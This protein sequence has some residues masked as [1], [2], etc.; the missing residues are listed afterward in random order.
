MGVTELIDYRCWFASSRDGVLGS[1]I[2]AH[3]RGTRT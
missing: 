1:I 2:K 3:I